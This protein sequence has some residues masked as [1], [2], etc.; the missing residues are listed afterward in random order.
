MIVQGTIRGAEQE[1]EGFIRD[2]SDTVPLMSDSKIALRQAAKIQRATLDEAQISDY[3]RRIRDNLI[4]L[5]GERDPVLVYAS[6]YP[7]VDT[8]PLIEWLLKEQKTVVVP[9]IQQEDCSLRLSCLSD[10]AVLV[11]STFQVPEPIGHEVPADPSK[12]QVVIV[13]MLA[14]DAT[15][16][17]LGYG[18]GYY[19]R[20]LAKHPDLLTIGLAFSCQE[21]ASLPAEENDIRMK[22]IVTE[23]R[24]ICCCGKDAV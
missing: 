13:P 7:E 2:R 17:R 23:E 3:S 4:P 12:I 11:P 24:I 16:N 15:G 6:K 19:D 5:L 1:K 14:F 21:A 22:W 20:F 8:I 10:P 18:A 9:I